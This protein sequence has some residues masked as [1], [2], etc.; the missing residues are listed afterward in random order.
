MPRLSTGRRIGRPSRAGWQFPQ[1]T[2]PDALDLLAMLFIAEDEPLKPYAL[3][4]KL[5]LEL[6]LD[7]SQFRNTKRLGNKL[8]HILREAK[9]RVYFDKNTDGRAVTFEEVENEIRHYPREDIRQSALT[10]VRE[11]ILNSS[12]TPTERRK[13]AEAH[14][15]IEEM[16]SKCDRAAWRLAK[17]EQA[18][19]DA[20][21]KNRTKGTILK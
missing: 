2:D 19:V 9:L 4:I 7:N 14:G 1:H 6:P 21:L 20:F 12:M 16:H 17:D 3:A 15:F 11:H 8:K 10:Y 5:D 13:L 18:L